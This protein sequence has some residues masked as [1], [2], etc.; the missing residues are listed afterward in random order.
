MIN[1]PER[2]AECGVYHFN[3]ADHLCTIYNGPPCITCGQPTVHVWEGAPGTG[4]GDVC[5]QRHYHGTHG[6]TTIEDER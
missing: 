4:R 5:K 1:I 6:I 2:C 3:G